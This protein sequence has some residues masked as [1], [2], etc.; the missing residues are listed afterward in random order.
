M[1]YERVFASAAVT[2]ILGV[3]GRSC[4]RQIIS[5]TAYNRGGGGAEKLITAK[6]PQKTYITFV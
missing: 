4:W 2:R 1:L 6:L 5:F 3:V